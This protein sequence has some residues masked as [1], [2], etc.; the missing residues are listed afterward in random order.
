MF[1]FIQDNNYDYIL[2]YKSRKFTICELCWWDT[3]YIYRIRVNNDTLTWFDWIEFIEEFA[4]L[5]DAKR[6]VVN[7]ITEQLK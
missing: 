4:T 3:D 1:E 6:A 5:E 2:E 7:F